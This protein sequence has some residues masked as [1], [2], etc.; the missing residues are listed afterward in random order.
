MTLPLMS[1]SSSRFRQGQQCMNLPHN[2]VKR[3]QGQMLE[4]TLLRPFSGHPR[5]NYDLCQKSLH[6][7]DGPTCVSNAVQR[8]YITRHVHAGKGPSVRMVSVRADTLGSTIVSAAKNV[9]VFGFSSR[10][11]LGKESTP[12][13]ADA[14]STRNRSRRRKRG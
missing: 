8:P 13:L 14:Q 7:I 11:A 1:S 12:C 3:L 2:S 10:E 6:R 5:T 9:K 4:L